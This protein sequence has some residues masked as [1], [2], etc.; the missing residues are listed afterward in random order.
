M[1]T[2]IRELTEMKAIIFEGFA[3]ECENKAFGKMAEWRKKFKPGN[4]RTFGHNIDA[5]GNL[6]YDP[7]HVGYKIFLCPEK[8]PEKIG[9]TK[10]GFIKP[11]KFVVVR[12]GGKIEEAGQWVMEGWANVNKMIAKKKLKVKDKACWYEEHITTPDPGYILLDLYLEID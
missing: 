5:D 7:E 10:P 1:E 12:I 11:G 9:D 3:P 8:M 4:C 2:S 6:S